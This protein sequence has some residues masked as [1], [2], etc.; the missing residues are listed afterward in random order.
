MR[1]GKLL[2]V[3]V[4]RLGE[5]Q[6]SKHLLKVCGHVPLLDHAAVVLDGQDHRIPEGAQ[7][8][9][10]IWFSLDK[11]HQCDQIW[12]NSLGRYEGMFLNGVE[13]IQEFDLRG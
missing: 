4:H 9:F 13:H 10:Q 2:S 11:L 3:V 6:I 1:R 5:Q 8:R 7:A 12:I